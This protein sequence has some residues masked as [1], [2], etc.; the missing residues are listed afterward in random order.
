MQTD[1][2]KVAQIASMNT[3]YIGAEGINQKASER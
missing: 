2:R 1:T 3:L